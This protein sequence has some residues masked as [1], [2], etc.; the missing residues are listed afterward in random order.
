MNSFIFYAEAQQIFAFLA[1][2]MQAGAK[3]QLIFAFATKI[4]IW[5]DYPIFKLKKYS[6]F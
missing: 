3:A 2:I 6:I 4:I 1:K 5:S